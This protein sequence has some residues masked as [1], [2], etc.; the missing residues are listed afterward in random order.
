MENKEVRRI[1][2]QNAREKVISK[3]ALL[4]CGYEGEEKFRTFRLEGAIPFEEFLSKLPSMNKSQEIIFYC[5]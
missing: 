3:E 4:V 5:A 1:E 2:P